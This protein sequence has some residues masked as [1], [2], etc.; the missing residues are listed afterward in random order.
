[1]TGRE[2]L[3]N[4]PYF[5][6]DVVDRDIPVKGGTEEAVNLLCDILE[7]LDLVASEEEAREALRA[8]IAVRRRYVSDYGAAASRDRGIRPSDL[9]E[10]VERF[11]ADDS[12]GGK[13]AQAIASGLLDLYASA[14]RVVTTRVNDPDRHLP[15]DIGIRAESDPSQWE[16]VFEVR[17]KPVSE[18]DLY[19]FVVKA[20]GSGVREAAV[21]AV[22]SGQQALN[23]ED[24]RD[25]ALQRGVALTVIIG[26]RA[27]IDQVLF[28]AEIGQIDAMDLVPVFLHDRMIQLEVGVAGVVFW[29]R[30]MEGAEA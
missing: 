7:E 30:L 8:F 21:L 22:A 25:F 19:A 24:A 29:R 2:P 16:K 5:R 4:Q 6:I 17:D 27:F 14:S 11:V 3:N 1:V 23:V 26:W 12:E 18:Q 20:A 10:L 13:R 28:W 9:V 15:G